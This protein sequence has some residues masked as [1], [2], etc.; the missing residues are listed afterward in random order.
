MKSVKLC[1]VVLVAVALVFSCASTGGGEQFVN[2]GFKWNFDDPEAGTAGW[3]TAPDEYWDFKGTLELSR[4]DIAF[5]RPMLRA[6]V[7]FS[8]DSG[9]WWSEPKLRFDFEEPIELRGLSR[10]NFDMYY[11]PEYSTTGSFKGKFIGFLNERSVVEA[12]LESIRA[13]EEVGGYYRAAV[14]FRFRSSRQ[15]DSLR[16]GIVGA[17]TNYNG[18]IFID[19]IRF[20]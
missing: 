3:V 19:N 1:F 5:G 9:S 4:D 15:I 6:D 12:E 17:V 20:E 16:I 18:P 2:E 7:D 11:N 14:S 8:K 10:L 13:V